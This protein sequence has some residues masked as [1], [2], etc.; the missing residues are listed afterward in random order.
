[1]TGLKKK[2]EVNLESANIIQDKQRTFV[3]AT[4]YDQDKIMNNNILTDQNIRNFRNGRVNY[5]T[6]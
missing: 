5:R 3:I 2:K 4:S 6:N 1:M